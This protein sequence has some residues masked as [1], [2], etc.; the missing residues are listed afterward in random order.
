MGFLRNVEK[1]KKESPSDRSRTGDQRIAANITVRC[2][3]NYTTEG[4]DITAECLRF[5]KLL[6]SANCSVECSCI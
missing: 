2:D 1:K 6:F 4:V 5:I 3:T